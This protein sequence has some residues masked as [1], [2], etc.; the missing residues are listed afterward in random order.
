MIMS[1]RH[2]DGTPDVLSDKIYASGLLKLEVC[3]IGNSIICLEMKT[4]A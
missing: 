4:Q 3:L 2:R 1:T